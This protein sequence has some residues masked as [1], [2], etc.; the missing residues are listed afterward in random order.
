MVP[1]LVFPLRSSIGVSGPPVLCLRARR[2]LGLFVMG[3]R[4]AVFVF[5]VIDRAAHGEGVSPLYDVPV[6]GGDP[7]LYDV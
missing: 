3:T 6:D 7:P 1:T 4:G 2:A 5:A